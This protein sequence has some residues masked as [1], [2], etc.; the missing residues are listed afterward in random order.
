MNSII[1]TSIAMNSQPKTIVL[2]HG[3]WM[4]P[5]S[6]DLFR[7][8]YEQRGYRVFARRGR[9]WRAMCRPWRQTNERK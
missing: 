5:S 3:L 6:L 4:T 2:I 1:D 8:F 7:D 9:G